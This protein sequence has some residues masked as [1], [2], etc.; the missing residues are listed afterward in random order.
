[1]KSP[2]QIEKDSAFVYD[3]RYLTMVSN[4]IDDGKH[5]L[6]LATE[7]LKFCLFEPKNKKNEKVIFPFALFAFPVPLHSS[8]GF[9][10]LQF[11]AQLDQNFPAASFHD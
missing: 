8:A 11:A 6:L 10:C 4:E 3:A 7:T 5:L 9:R 1:M 2:R